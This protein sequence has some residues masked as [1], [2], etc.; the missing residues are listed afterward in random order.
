MEILSEDYSWTKKMRAPA[1][2]RLQKIHNMDLVFQILAKQGVTV[3][4][5]GK[6]KYKMILI[7][8]CFLK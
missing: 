8:I 4:K 2:S 1:I 6:K 5:K 3:D 7:I